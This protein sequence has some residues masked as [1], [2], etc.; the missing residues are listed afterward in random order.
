MRTVHSFIAALSG[1]ASGR[2]SGGLVYILSI[3][4]LL[5]EVADTSDSDVF[6]VRSDTCM[7]NWCKSSCDTFGTFKFQLKLFLKSRLY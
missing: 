5:R 4:L 3:V 7:F 2:F 1:G 6:A